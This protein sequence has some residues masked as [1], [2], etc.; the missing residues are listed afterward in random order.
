VARH[1]IGVAARCSGE[2]RVLAVGGRGAVR[3]SW[4]RSKRCAGE[5]KGEEREDRLGEREESGVAEGG[6]GN[7]EQGGRA[8][9]LLDGPNWA[10]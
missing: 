5:S 9:L 4:R 10:G 3:G 2:S 7:R 6:G 1:D 8:R